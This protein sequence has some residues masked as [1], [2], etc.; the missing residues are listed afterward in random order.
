MG[1]TPRVKGERRTKKRRVKMG[2][3]KVEKEK[4]DSRRPRGKE[5]IPIR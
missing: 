5:K 3:A 1:R 2:R 4:R